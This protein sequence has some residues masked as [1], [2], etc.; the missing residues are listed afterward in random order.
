MPGILLYHLGCIGLQVTES[1]TYTGLN[2]G[3]FINSP[4]WKSNCRP[5]FEIYLI[6]G[7]QL[8]LQDPLGY[9]LFC[10]LVSYQA[11]L[12][13]SRKN[14]RSWFRLHISTLPVLRGKKILLSQPSPQEF[15]NSPDCLSLGD[16]PTR[17]QWLWLEKENTRFSIRWSC[18]T[19]EASPRTEI[20]WAG[21]RKGGY[22]MRFWA[23]LRKGM[24]IMDAR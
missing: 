19:S 5:K 16:M 9:A 11:D 17:D 12:P 10:V 22:S 1:L 20:I 23:L 2:R 8:I 13:S 4:N 15:W 7:P 14:D 3:E 6:Q 24:G 21:R 18:P